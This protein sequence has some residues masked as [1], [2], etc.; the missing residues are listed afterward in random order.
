MQSLLQALRA[1]AEPTRL[2]ILGLCGHGELTVTDLVNILGQS[3]PRVS[4][5]LR[6]LVEA[7][8]LDR[9]QEGNW[10]W[11]RLA[12]RDLS[13][14]L[15]RQLIDLIPDDDPALALDL[16]RLEQVKADRARAAEAYFRENAADWNEIRALHV[17]QAK[18]DTALEKVLLDTPVDDLLDIG[19]GTG[20]ILELAGPHVKSAIGIDASREMLSVARLSLD[21]ASLRNCQVRQADMYALPFPAARFDLVTLHMVLHYAEDPA[22]AVA[23]AARVLRPGGR[24]VLVDF[25]AHDMTSLQAQ[26]AHRWLGFDPA[27]AERFFDGAGLVSGPP[28]RLKGS[29]LTVCI[30]SA[31][32]LANDP[33]ERTKGGSASARGARR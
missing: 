6:L 8:L 33:G 11:Y 3:Q 9:F 4:R 30:W 17:D 28:V 12:D 25:A 31:R 27:V 2:R 22:R 26:H 5:H 32:R 15:A 24:M 19:T 10:A 29:P 7:G 23:E 20:S 21:R 1:A 14:E 16:E 13:G 18:V